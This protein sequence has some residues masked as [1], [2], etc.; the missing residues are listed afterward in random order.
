MGAMADRLISVVTNIG[1]DTCKA[2]EGAFN[3][4]NHL[5]IEGCSRDEV[6]TVRR[7]GQFF[8]A[9]LILPSMPPRR[10]YT[11]RN[12]K[13][14][15]DQIAPPAA[16]APPPRIRY[17]DR[18]AI[19]EHLHCPIC[20]EVFNYPIAL[21]CGHVFCQPCIA[22]WLRPNNQKT[23]PE[24]RQVVDMRYSHRDLIAHRFLDSVPVYCSFL[25]C[26][27]IGRMDALQGHV[28]ECDCNPAILPDYMVSKEAEPASV[29]EDGPSE[30]TT[31]LRMKLFK[32]GKR[33]LLDTV[34]SGSSS[35]FRPSA[36]SSD[37]PH[38]RLSDLTSDL[39]R[40]S[41]VIS[42]NQPQTDHGDFIDLS[43]SD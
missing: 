40:S 33:D 15:S 43:D 14:K 21:Q 30:G 6:L 25:G 32:G 42:R 38:I 19:S 18:D 35:I 26:S 24:C 11:G 37:E 16:P 9:N 13:R 39:V 31:S 36:T 41:D 34:G 23:C 29:S 1:S 3:S 5:R 28:S 22:Q 20:Q 8:S 4:I 10:S 2:P 17:F 7:M 27:W 12:N